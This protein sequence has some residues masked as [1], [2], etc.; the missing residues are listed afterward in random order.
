MEYERYQ[1]FLDQVKVNCEEDLID[2]KYR[3][4][5]PHELTR[6]SIEDEIPTSVYQEY[7]KRLI[8]LYIQPIMAFTGFKF[9]VRDFHK[10]GRK[11]KKITFQFICS[12]DR[13]K[14]R[15]SRSNNERNVNN[16][17]KV[18]DCD[19]RINL[20]YTVTTGLVT[21]AFTHKTH[22]PYG[23]RPM[24][25][26]T[27]EQFH[28]QNHTT[29]NKTS[30]KPSSTTASGSS[31]AQRIDYNLQSVA[32]YNSHYQGNQFQPFND[33]NAVQALAAVATQNFKSS[34][35]MENIDKELIGLQEGV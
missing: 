26:S 4:E 14:Q 17:L 1:D 13:T 6:F 21:I 33:Q 29:G 12:Q 31:Q 18:E 3:G 34:E 2:L 8:E 24:R 25:T 10:G 22:S 35:K 30:T 23:S 15:K 16:K 11:T 7:A 27:L 9:V 19:S 28:Q 32:Q 20:M 5:A